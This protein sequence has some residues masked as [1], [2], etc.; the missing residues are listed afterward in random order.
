MNFSER[1]FKAMGLFGLVAVVLIIFNY[2]VNPYPLGFLSLDH[3][4]VYLSGGAYRYRVAFLIFQ[5]LLIFL[6]LWGLAVKSH[7]VSGGLVATGFLV[8]IPWFALDLIPRAIELFAVSVQW[9]PA[10]IEVYEAGNE[11]AQDRVFDSIRELQI[12]VAP[13]V[14]LSKLLWGL[15]HLLLALALIR[16]EGMG[17]LISVFGF[18]LAAP[19]FVG[20]LDSYYDLGFAWLDGTSLYL[21]TMIP[22]FGLTGL[23]LWLSPKV[24]ET[25]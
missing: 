5:S 19:V 21:I 4:M 14:E 6:T 2:V 3:L 12:M 8:F 20:L 18:L 15:G 24:E 22:Y 23:W 25:G 16:I 7:R 10:W 1:F 13:L 17:R 9:A 11:A